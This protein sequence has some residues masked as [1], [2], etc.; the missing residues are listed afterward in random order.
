MAGYTGLTPDFIEKINLIQIDG[1]GSNKKVEKRIVYTFSTKEEIISREDLTDQLVTSLDDPSYIYLVSG[2]A[3]AYDL[4]PFR[5]LRKAI[6]LS[7]EINQTES[8]E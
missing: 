5:K 8:G 7:E 3:G 1:C 4:H 6:V 2:S